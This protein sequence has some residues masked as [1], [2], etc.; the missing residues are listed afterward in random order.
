M[1]VRADFALPL[2]AQL[3]QEFPARLIGRDPVRYQE[4][5]SDSMVLK[6]RVQQS[7]EPHVTY[8]RITGIVPVSK[9][10]L[11][12]DIDADSKFHRDRR[13]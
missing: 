11:F 5:G 7:Q 9:E 2:L 8:R 1:Q 12:L 3:K 10:T 6:H 13:L 4:S